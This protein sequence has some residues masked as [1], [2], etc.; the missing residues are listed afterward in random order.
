MYLFSSHSHHNTLM[1][2]R[3]FT[4]EWDN[5]CCQLVLNVLRWMGWVG[6]M[7]GCL[8]ANTADSMA[9]SIKASGIFLIPSV[10]SMRRTLLTAWIRLLAFSKSLNSCSMAGTTI[11]AITLSMFA[12]SAGILL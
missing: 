2:E 4:Q 12:L 1:H 6:I 5:V 10:C 8:S 7:G 11:P 9:V 3:Y